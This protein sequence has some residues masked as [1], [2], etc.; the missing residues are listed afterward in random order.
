MEDF[1]VGH[2][3]NFCPSILLPLLFE[4]GSFSESQLAITFFFHPLR[5][6]LR[7]AA[8]CKS[9]STT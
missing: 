6:A 5:A 9:S 8:I 1:Y 7:M 3:K 2:F 4:S